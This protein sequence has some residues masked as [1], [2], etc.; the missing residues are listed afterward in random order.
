[1]VDRFVAWRPRC[2]ADDGRHS[3]VTRK[4]QRRPGSHGV[5]DEH[6]RYVAMAGSRLC[7]RSPGVGD[8]RRLGAVP[9]AIAVADMLDDESVSKATGPQRGG[10]RTH[11]EA[12]A[13]APGH[14][15]EAV[16]L[17]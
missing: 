9:A 3:V 12:G 4:S 14:R 2:E 13:A 6:D 10:D 7:Q 17:A 1:M 16:L 11:P 8:G 15:V 5:T